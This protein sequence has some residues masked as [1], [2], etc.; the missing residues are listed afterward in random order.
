MSDDARSFQFPK[1]IVTR[2]IDTH[3]KGDAMAWQVPSQK[4]IKFPWNFAILYTWV[5]DGYYQSVVS[6]ARTLDNKQ[7]MAEPRI[8]QPEVKR[9]N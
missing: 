2:S 5:K 7:V 9:V 6:G 8:F 3:S 4:F 1:Q